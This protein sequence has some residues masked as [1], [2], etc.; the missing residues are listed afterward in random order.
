MT[1]HVPLSA[2]GLMRMMRL[3]A[4]I[5]SVSLSHPEKCDCL[6]CRAGRGD[7][8]AFARIA[9]DLADSL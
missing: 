2:E 1:D 3:K 4:A 8:A 6:T 5:A 7:E 9:A